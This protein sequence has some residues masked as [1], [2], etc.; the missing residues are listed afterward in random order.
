MLA[1]ESAVPAGPFGIVVPARR[2]DRVSSLRGE[3]TPVEGSLDPGVSVERLRPVTNR[4]HP[5]DLSSIGLIGPTQLVLFNLP[6]GFLEEAPV[7]TKGIT[8]HLGR[9]PQWGVLPNESDPTANPRR[10]CVVDFGAIRQHRN[11]VQ[12]R[13]TGEEYLPDALR[14]AVVRQPNNSSASAK[15][16]LQQESDVGPPLAYGSAY[17]QSDLEPGERPRRKCPEPVF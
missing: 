10:I 11:G 17:C 4:V 6:L 12:G 3:G 2:P 13:Q 15:A 5:F 16:Q 14:A 8:S 7:K 1:I 9:R